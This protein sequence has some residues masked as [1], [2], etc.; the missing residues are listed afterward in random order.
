[1]S[2]IDVVLLL[3]IDISKPLLI[4]GNSLGGSIA[5]LF[6]LWLLD[7][8][9]SKPSKRPICITFGSPLLGDNHFQKA[10]KERSSWPSCFLHV[11]FNLDPMPKLFISP[12]PASLANP[13]YKPFGSFLF[14]SKS[15]CA[16][17]DDPDSVFELLIAMSS[18]S[19]GNIDLAHFQINYYGLVLDN[20]KKNTILK[21]TSE[22]GDSALNP[23][24]VGLTLQLEAIG[25]IKPQ[26]TLPTQFYISTSL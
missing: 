7:T 16:C 6:T 13:T 12:N 3:Q 23:L 19:V 9:Y 18:E 1:M 4:T 2:K 11:V 14:C 10:I 26:V 24:R 8:V 20:L 25:V 22:L 21:G 15:R 17:F 5:S